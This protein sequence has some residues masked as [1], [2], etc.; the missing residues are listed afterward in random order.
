MWSEAAVTTIGSSSTASTC[1]PGKWWLRKLG[2]EP[3]PRPMH[4]TLE[5]FSPSA[6][7]L[8]TGWPVGDACMC[9]CLCVC[10]LFTLLCAIG[11]RVVSSLPV[12]PMI[13]AAAR[14]DTESVNKPGPARFMSLARLN[15]YNL[16]E[17]V[18]ENTLESSSYVVRPIQ[19]RYVHAVCQSEDHAHVSNYSCFAACK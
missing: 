10:L 3:P 9:G 7:D 17:T 12:T 19:L 2:R 14:T 11:C 15:K 8:L 1:S 18:F 5:A 16:Y 4:S 6:M 13:A